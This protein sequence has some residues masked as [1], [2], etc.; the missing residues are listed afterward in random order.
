MNSFVI[1]AFCNDQFHKFVYSSL[2]SFFF[3]C[4]LPSLNHRRLVVI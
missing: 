1:L 2:V 3:S 4:A